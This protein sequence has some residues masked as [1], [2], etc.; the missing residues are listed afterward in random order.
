MDL[1]LLALAGGALA[2]GRHLRLYPASWDKR[3]YV[4][5]ARYRGARNE[6]RQARARRR[7]VQHG[8]QRAVEAVQ[9]RVAESG[10]RSREL[11]RSLKEEREKL[12]RPQL[13]PALADDFG[14]LRLHEH[15]LQFL[16]VTPDA[17]PT[18]DGDPLRLAR[19]TVATELSPQ[20][21][22]YINV[23]TSDG[24][25][26]SAVY[27]RG[28]YEERDVKAFRNRIR[29]QALADEEFARSQEA[30]DA[31]LTARIDEIEADEDR[32]RQAGLREVEELVQAQQA[33][34][35]RLEAEQKW[36]YAR[37]NWAG[38]AHRQPPLWARP[39]K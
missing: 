38:D 30:R 28:R 39:W 22:C 13:G 12:R 29:R 24:D 33:A 31:E 26:R 8:E 3:E 16:R 4:Y 36:Q 9:A 1:L 2:A 6:L 25:E 7:S 18:P 11:V 5:A 34:P 14:E 19:I 20:E 21:N 17:A 23:T 10:R 35:E 15:H 32:S 27:P 37:K